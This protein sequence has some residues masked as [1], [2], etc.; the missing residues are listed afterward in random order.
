MREA[1]DVLMIG[2]IRDRQTLENALV[3]AQTG[4][5]CLATLHANNSYNALNR[6]ISFFPRDCAR[7]C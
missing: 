3:F 6:I 4:H 2:E 5:L 7:V 1:P